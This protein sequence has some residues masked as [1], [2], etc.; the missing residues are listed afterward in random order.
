MFEWN[1]DK[2]NTNIAKHNVSFDDAKMAFLDQKRLVYEDA[3][4]S[5]HEKRWFCIGVVRDRVLTVRF[6]M[7]E[8]KIR[9]IGAAYW[10]KGRAE[11]EKENGNIKD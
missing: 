1:P 2:D 6:T 4:H 11:Y 5:T 10:R 8:K 3:E 9:I 7:R